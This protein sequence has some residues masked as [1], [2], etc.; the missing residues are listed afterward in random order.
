[1][2]SLS[3]QET[4]QT[5]IPIKIDFERYNFLNI[6]KMDDSLMIPTEVIESGFPKLIF[7]KRFPMLKFKFNTNLLTIVLVKNQTLFDPVFENLKYNSVSDILLISDHLPNPTQTLKTFA[8]HK[9]LNTIFINKKTSKVY[10]FEYFPGFALVEEEFERTTNII[11][12][13]K[14]KS[15]HKKLVK[16]ACVKSLPRCMDGIDNKGNTKFVGYLSHILRNFARFLNGTFEFQNFNESIPEQ[17]M[18]LVLA[19]EL[20]DFVTLVKFHFSDNS[21]EQMLLNQNISSILGIINNYVIVPS[22]KPTDKMNYPVKPFAIAVW[23]LLFIFLFYSSFLIDCG[24]LLKEGKT[25]VGLYSECILRAVLA[26]SFPLHNRQKPAFLSIVFLIIEIFGFIVTLW[27]CAVLGSFVT[28]T[29]YDPAIDSLEGIRRSNLK[30]LLGD[31]YGYLLQKYVGIESYHDLF[32]LYPLQ[33][34]RRLKAELNQNYA[35]VEASD[36]WIYYLKPL[37]KFYGVDKFRTISNNL[38]SVA[39]YINLNHDSVYK[40]SLNRFLAISK[41]VGLFDFWCKRTFLDSLIYNI[42]R[43]PMGQNTSHGKGKVLTVQFFKIVF[44]GWFIGITLASIIFIAE[45]ICTY[46]WNKSRII[47][48]RSQEYF[49]KLN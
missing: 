23:L 26:Q 37:Q 34:F 8:D 17:N 14:V 48:I 42:Y 27:Y 9:F 16:I 10:Y 21:T 6:L 49:F 22:P 20:V 43:K 15:I 25:D 18:E 32:S 5:N 46:R 38:L 11:F 29:L 39:S 44:I 3:S 30:I 33:E 1:M 36:R 2:I 12:E 13:N 41:D 35:Y 24:L 19:E 4:L 45:K 47:L 40:K 7:S 28:A 31:S